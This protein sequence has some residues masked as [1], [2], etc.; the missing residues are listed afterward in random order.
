M[1]FAN[2]R[3]KANAKKIECAAILC[4]IFD[5]NASLASVQCF[6]MCCTMLNNDWAIWFL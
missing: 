1:A 3:L 5:A 2:N 4:K 6:S